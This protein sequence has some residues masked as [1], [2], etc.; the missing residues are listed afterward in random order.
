MSV[1]MGT[2]HAD[3]ALGAGDV[4]SVAV[5]LELVLQL[6]EIVSTWHNQLEA[7]DKTEQA[8]VATRTLTAASC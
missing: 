8:R 6:V 1:F 7:A 4:P 5:N 2:T 3:G